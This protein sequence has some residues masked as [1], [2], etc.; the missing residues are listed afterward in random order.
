MDQQKFE[1]KLIKFETDMNGRWAHQLCGMM[2]PY[3]VNHSFQD[4]SL[5]M[6]FP[7]QSWEENPGGVI[8]GGAM[9]SMIDTC[10]GVL[11]GALAGRLTPTISLQLNYLRPA[12]ADGQIIVGAQVT[13]LGHSIIYVSSRAW[14]SRNPDK[15]LATAEA[16]YK[17]QG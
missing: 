11:C 14:D 5:E 3:I 6:G 10:S 13:M 15:L 8:H 12:P 4:M 2:K 9:A 16:T 1:Q 17:N 7:A